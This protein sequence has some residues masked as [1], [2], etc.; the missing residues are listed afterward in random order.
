MHVV[1]IFVFYLVVYQR[2]QYEV[3]DFGAGDGS[4][5][6]AVR[7]AHLPTAEV[8][9]DDALSLD[10]TLVVDHLAVPTSCLQKSE[11]IFMRCIQKNIYLPLCN[12]Y[13]LNRFDLKNALNIT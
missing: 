5:L 1:Y 10:A 4:E 12:A 9:D 8:L 11:H 3:D 13:I 7:L 6:G 2:F